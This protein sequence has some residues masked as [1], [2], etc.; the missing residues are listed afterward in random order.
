MC[1]VLALQPVLHHWVHVIVLIGDCINLS[2][3]TL[4]IVKH[5]DNYTILKPREPFVPIGIKIG[6][7]V[8]KISCSQVW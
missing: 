7:F 8:F 5:R 3:V 4:V 6:F 2:N 1:V